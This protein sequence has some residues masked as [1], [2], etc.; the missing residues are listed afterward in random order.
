MLKT[1]GE[2]IHHSNLK[3]IFENICLILQLQAH[4]CVN[5]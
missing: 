3:V 4:E 2:E 1:L 5:D